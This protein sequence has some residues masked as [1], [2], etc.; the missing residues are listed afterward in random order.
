VPRA[1]VIPSIPRPER[2]ASLS[3]VVAV[4]WRILDLVPARAYSRED[5]PLPVE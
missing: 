2:R 5:G 1:I 3:P 4:W